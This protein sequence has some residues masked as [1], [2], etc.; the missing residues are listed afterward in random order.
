MK[1]EKR[2]R[3]IIQE[4][5]GTQ[6]T[7]DRMSG[8][9]STDILLTIQLELHKMLDGN[10]RGLKANTKSSIVVKGDTKIRNV[11][12]EI[13]FTYSA[14][15]KIN[16]KFMP[17]KSDFLENRPYHNVYIKLDLST[18]NATTEFLFPKIDSFIT[19]E[20][21]HAFTFI[22]TLNTKNRA[23]TL[24]QTQKYTKD[25]LQFYLNTIPALKKF[26]DMIYL[27]NPL[28][29]Q[30]RVHQTGNEIKLIKSQ[31]SVETIDKLFFYNPIRDAKSMINYNMDE[32]RKVDEK[33]LLNFISLFNKG[34]TD[35]YAD[36]K[37]E[38]ITDKEEFLDYW[39]KRIHLAGYKLAN[40]ILKIVADKHNIHEY[41]VMEQI[42]G[43]GIYKKIFGEY[44]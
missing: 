25:G 31:N 29:V 8:Y 35:F 44:L 18:N 2:I 36:E 7:V 39:I 12:V 3:K 16:G 17:S 38:I 13:N 9:V 11:E 43:E 32:L 22:K 23:W 19:H 1:N 5:L 14:N 6:M 34:L 15:F 41:Y 21:N 20:L 28:E 26:S 10:P 30:A 42:N 37:P 33:L 40:K 4:V 24:N 27:S